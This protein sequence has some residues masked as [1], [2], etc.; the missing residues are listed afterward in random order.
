[1]RLLP[2]ADLAVFDAIVRHGGVRAAARHLGI[3]HSAVSRRLTALESIIGEPLLQRSSGGSPVFQLTPRGVALSAATRDAFEQLQDA[4]AREPTQKTH[5]SVTVSTTSAFASRWLLPRLPDFQSSHKRIQVSVTVSRSLVQPDRDGVD[6]ALR[7]GRGPW[8]GVKALPWM[9]DALVPLASPQ[10]LGDARRSLPL[11]S[12]LDMRLLQDQDPAASWMR[13]AD[14]VG[15]AKLAQ[16]RGIT[17]D[18][19]EL[20]IQAA[21]EG[22]GVALVPQRL[23]PHEL[24]RGEL[25]APFGPYRILLPQ[26]YW[27]VLPRMGKERPAVQRFV[28]WLKTCSED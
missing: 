9:D 8:P 3:A 5:E 23:A 26:A 18:S 19:S 4:L 25:V 20:L 17:F 15:P 16:Q 6:V 1:M 2:L 27:I 21:R 7:M 14:E 24:E 10:L 22:L 13:W 11:K 28:Q 12:L